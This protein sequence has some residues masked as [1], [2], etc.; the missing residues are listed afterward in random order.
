MAHEMEA[1]GSIVVL[2]GFAAGAPDQGYNQAYA[3][4]GVERSEI[5]S[6]PT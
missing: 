3:L 5:S 6:G 1:A 2:C 4:C